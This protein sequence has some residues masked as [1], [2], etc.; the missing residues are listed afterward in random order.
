MASPFKFLDSYNKK[1]ALIFF[2]RESET[3]DLYSR[4]F[5]S[6]M[7]V[8]YG[9]SGTGKT[10]L[11]F[12]G[13]ANRFEDSDWMPIQV[14]RGQNI[15][16]SLSQNIRNS[17][18]TEIPDDET[19]LSG[20]LKSVYLDH[21][22]PIFIV[23][24]QFEE[25]FIYGNREEWMLLAKNIRTVL[26]AKLQVKFLFAIRG[27]YL[28]YLTE[29]ESVL[30]GIFENRTRLEKMTRDKAIDCIKG[31]CKATGIKVEDRFAEEL[32]DRLT[33]KDK[34]E[35]E[36]TYLQVYLDKVYKIA[37]DGGKIANEKITFTRAML[38]KVGKIEDVLSQFLEEQI[39]EIP[40]PEN[41]IDVLKAFVSREAT[42]KQAT[43]QQVVEFLGTIENPLTEDKV[44]SL[45]Q[46]LV[47][48]RI[49]KEV[50]GGRYEFRHDSL[51][52]RVRT[53]ITDLEQKL[54]EVRDF[55]AAALKEKKSRHALL[56]EKDL[57]YI[58]GFDKLALG[59]EEKKLVAES[60]ALVDSAKQKRQRIRMLVVAAIFS[61]M[62]VSALGWINTAWN[63]ANLEKEKIK[64]DAL[65]D[66]S[67]NNA[68]RYKALF[69]E[70]KIIA[71]EKTKAARKSDSLYVIAV[72]ER[73][74]AT[75]LAIKA[76]DQTQKAEREAENAK[77]QSNLANKE[78]IEAD[79]A[80]NKAKREEKR[81]E[82]ERYKNES[83]A[84]ALQ[85][86]LEPDPIARLSKI[87]RSYYLNGQVN[88][89]DWMP[90]IVT[91]FVNAVPKD[92]AIHHIASATTT[93]VAEL[94]LLKST[95]IA[96]N[97]L[98]R[99]ML[100]DPDK[101]LVKGMKENSR[102]YYYRGNSAR[103]NP[104]RNE[105]SVEDLQQRRYVYEFA[106]SAFTLVKEDVSK[107]QH[108]F[109]VT[110]GEL[111]LTPGRVLKTNAVGST[112][113]Q[114]FMGVQK[115]RTLAI[116]PDAS[117]SAAGTDVGWIYVWDVRQGVN[118][119]KGQFQD[120][121]TPALDIALDN[122]GEFVATGGAD[123]KFRINKKFLL[124]KNAPF[125]WQF[126]SK[127]SAVLFL[128]KMRV[129]V[130]T[131]SGQLYI[132]NYSQDALADCACRELVRQIAR[133]DKTKKSDGMVEDNETVVDDLV[134]K[135]CIQKNR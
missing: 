30:P 91:G 26:D 121:S 97:D 90:E 11:I 76:D 29:F 77:V 15:N 128:S 40:E 114:Q 57:E 20:I 43:V 108:S 95:V 69:E 72:A 28:E 80:R 21:F 2:G 65:A 23:F 44:E 82:T 132:V 74:K 48:R 100:I 109:Q 112:L 78:K 31:P 35:V 125:K 122:D 126:D 47:R 53:K 88:N 6:K 99:F 37:S 25:L 12:C 9:P 22:K 19:T 73:S 14:R 33:K 68:E 71:A 49:L 32:L 52:A 13:L 8:I 27:E 81:A 10:S 38:E 50:D 46:E 131:T 61:L 115:G 58:S 54:I 119:F 24:D 79:T 107:G 87:L 106:D 133:R 85:S 103:S 116:S 113:A 66:S 42:K 4:C 39:S 134:I 104:A 101:H 18:L 36:L 93:S 60:Q 3:D 123:S 92:S 94:I 5:K 45:I 86:V 135:K 110:D 124:K 16:K 17:G 62:I 105:I 59:D 34:P 84:L 1:D 120:V 127:V 7:L 51:A 75:K 63:A 41:A 102:L 89:C 83:L 70:N 129:L 117:V 55:L 64:A 111:V 130:G 118:Y 56:N 98:G 96:I 67:A